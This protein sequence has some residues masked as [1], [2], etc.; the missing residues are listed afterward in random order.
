MTSRRNR[1]N[2]TMRWGCMAGWRE[3]YSPLEVLSIRVS[4]V[5]RRKPPG[6]LTGGRQAYCRIGCCV[7]AGNIASI[8]CMIFA[9][10]FTASWI[11]DSS[12][13]RACVQLA[14]VPRDEDRSGDEQNALA[15]FIH[16]GRNNTLFVF[17]RHAAAGKAALPEHYKF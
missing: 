4:A 12:A 16:G 2:L 15:A 10:M 11:N 7:P 9:A 17:I 5:K 13:R 3:A 14:Q 8:R 1:S 6:R